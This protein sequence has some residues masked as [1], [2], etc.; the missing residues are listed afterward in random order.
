MNLEEFLGTKSALIQRSIRRLLWAVSLLLI[1]LMMGVGGFYYFEGY[2]L[3]DAFYMTVITISTVGF[4][5]VEPLSPVGRFFTSLYI[6]FNMCVL[7]YV[8]SVITTYLFEGELK[9]VLNQFK[10]G[11][12]VKRLKDH[13]I[14]CGFGRTGVKAC[15]E[16]AKSNREFVVIDSDPDSTNLSPDSAHYHFILG[17]ATQ[18][19]TLRDAGIERAHAIITTLPKDADNVF[20][21]LTAREMNPN[22]KIIARA[23][24]V[25][26]EKKLYRAG[27]SQVVMPDAIG[28][29]HMAQLVTKPDV[30]EFLKLLNGVGNVKFKVEEINFD[31]FKNEFQNKTIKELDVRRK[32]GA[33]VIGMKD[34]IQGFLFNP[35]ADMVIGPDDTLIIVGYEKEVEAFRKWY[36]KR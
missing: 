7:A 8:V 15:E 29:L 33:T 23:S 21:S 9:R 10:I 35:H 32:T 17:D 1:S 6:V 18:D 34:D 2:D 36:A 4:A 16:L 24:D 12:G 11:R 3:L 19:D 27:A 20:I 28:G 5:E 31:E 25:N 22:M 30:I 14:V 26:S 13:V